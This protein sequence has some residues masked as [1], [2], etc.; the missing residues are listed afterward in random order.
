M[1]NLFSYP[2]V[3]D[4]LPA[5]ERK[6]HL[7][8]NE[9][10]LEYLKEVLQVEGVKS[11]SAEI[12]LKLYKKEHRLDVWGSVS[13]ELELKSVI[14]LENFYKTY[15]PQFKI[16]YDTKATMKEIKELEIDFNEDEPD[17]VIDGK[18]DL[19]QIAIEQVALVM[20]DNPRKEGEVF[21]FK[22]EFDEKDTEALNP[23]SVLRKL[24][25]EE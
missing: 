10:E 6:Y 13:A 11:F 22:S 8:A 20:D 5:T 1:Q 3:V 16:Y 18:I 14:S 9:D 17:I 23:F 15:T 7:K 21:V 2:I 4:D 19:G 25:K 24:K 12:M